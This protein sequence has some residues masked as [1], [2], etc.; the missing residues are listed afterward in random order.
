[1]LNSIYNHLTGSTPILGQSKNYENIYIQF[2]V[3][4]TFVG[5]QTFIRY[6]KCQKIPRPNR[7]NSQLGA[8]ISNG[9][10]RVTP[11]G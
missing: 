11:I 10:N 8:I 5:K 2:S 1:M 3:H 7:F 4:D 9:L 6:T